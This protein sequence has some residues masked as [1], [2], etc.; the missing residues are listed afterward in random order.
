MRRISFSPVVVLTIVAIGGLIA[1]C[2]KAESMGPEDTPQPPSS[3]QWEGASKEGRS[4]IAG[5]PTLS[6]VLNK[7]FADWRDDPEAAIEQAIEQGLEIE[8]D[9]VK[10]LLIMLDEDSVEGT[11]DVISEL[12]GEVTDRYQMWI[13]AWVP[14][15]SLDAIAE[16]PD[17]SQVREPIEVVPL[18]P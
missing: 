13:D 14:I 16:L 9:R 4:E 8:D 2:V 3:S 15:G 10:V 12:G 6:T 11:V 17:L 1:G 18:D 7:L 5:L